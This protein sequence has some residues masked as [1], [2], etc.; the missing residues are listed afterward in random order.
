M[1]TFTIGV[2]VAI[3]LALV[4]LDVVARSPRSTIATWGGVVRRVLRSRP[5]QFGL[6]LAWWWLGVHFL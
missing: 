2:F 6:L 4:A 5:A 1:R 3:G